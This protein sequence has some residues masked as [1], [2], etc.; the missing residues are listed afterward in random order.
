[1]NSFQIKGRYPD[2]AE[3]LE[4]TITKEICEEYLIETK[5]MILCLQRKLQ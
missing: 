5:Q 1:M 2:Y 3:S 4:K